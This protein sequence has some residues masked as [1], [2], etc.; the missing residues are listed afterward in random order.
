MNQA[1]QLEAIIAQLRAAEAKLKEG[2]HIGFAMVCPVIYFFALLY[3]IE[4][5]LLIFTVL[6]SCLGLA[7]LSYYWVT[8]LRNRRSWYWEPLR[9]EIG[10]K[11][12]NQ[13][14]DVCEHGD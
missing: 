6:C 10:G 7:I 8:A 2:D 4:G 1:Q 3:F 9:R 12:L 5:H 11:D 13:M 14:W